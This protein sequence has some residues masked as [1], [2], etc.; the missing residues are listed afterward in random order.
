[1]KARRVFAALLIGL[2]VSTAASQSY[3]TQATYPSR[4]IRFVV[5]FPAGGTT[6]TV[7]RPVAQ[8]LSERLGQPVLVENRPGG[9]TI[10]GAEAVAKA[11]PDG[12]TLFFTTSSTIAILPHTKKNLPFDPFKSFVHVA[13]IAYAQFVLAVNPAVPAANVAELIALARAKPGE[14]SYAAGSEA[15]RLTAEMLKAATGTDIIYVPYKGAAP[16]TTDLLSG[17]VNMMFTAIAGTVPYFNAK[18]LRALAVSGDHRAPGLPDV[19]TMAEAGVKDFESSS[20]WGMSAPAGTPRVVVEKLNDAVG[21]VIEMP[22]IVEKLLAQ[23]TEPRRASPEQFTATLK[24][25][26]EKNRLVLA[27]IGIKAE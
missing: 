10:I 13:Q 6:D 3:S 17:Q 11:A 19:P 5:P 8:K 16:A 27:R 1:M 26:S 7:A 9:E 15:G 24:A 25:E 2:A 22:D 23:G 20:A 4:P 18:R 14:L 21:A 12:Y